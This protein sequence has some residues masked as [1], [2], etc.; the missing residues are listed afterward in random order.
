MK[1]KGSA[2]WAG[3]L[4]DGKGTVS[5]ES[6]VLK[7]VQYSFSSRFESGAGS[8]PEEL[9]GA[10]HAGC[11]SMAFSA[12]LGASGYTPDRIATTATVAVEPVEGGFGITSVHLDVEASIPGI[13]D[14]QFQEIAAAAKAGCP[15][16]KLFN[17]NITMTA[18]L[19]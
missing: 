6:G 5:T 3:G 9:L 16:S 8:N 17:T 12:Q 7:D 4:K 19:V 10:A 18:K 1:R 15:V 13:D 14:S 2:V 11:F